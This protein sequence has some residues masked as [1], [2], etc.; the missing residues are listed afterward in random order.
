MNRR[1]FL[2]SAAF[3]ASAL[4]PAFA[5]SP[6]PPAGYTTPEA[7]V[8]WIYIQAVKPEKDGS[9]TG[10]TIFNKG[11]PSRRLFSS[12]FMRDWNVGQARIKKSGEMGLDFDPVSNSQDPAI[13]K[14]DIRVESETGGK[15]T[16]AATFGSLH[17]PKAKPTTV[18]Y[19]FIRDD[20]GWRIDDIRGSVEKD[21]WSMRQIMKEWK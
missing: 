21:P 8:R 9:Q 13:G 19:D 12:A 11:G 15:A 1:V 5:Q 10:G 2:L 17:E 14:V 18:R 20:A 7:I 16:V 3:A 4:V 6:V